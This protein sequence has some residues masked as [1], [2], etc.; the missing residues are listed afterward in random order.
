M[1]GTEGLLD[2]RRSRPGV[3]QPSQ[4]SDP[5]LGRDGMESGGRPNDDHTHTARSALGQ[6]VDHPL[7]IP[8]PRSTLR[9]QSRGC[10][11]GTLRSTGQGGQL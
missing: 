10:I 11:A 5:W 1:S 9:H 2:L 7:K 6:T 4:A 8:P 3:S